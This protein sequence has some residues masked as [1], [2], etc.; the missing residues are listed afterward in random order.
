MQWLVHRRHS[1]NIFEQTTTNKSMDFGRTED[2]IAIEPEPVLHRL[3]FWEDTLGLL[4]SPEE[5]CL[6]SQPNENSPEKDLTGKA[7]SCNYFSS[8]LA[9]G[10]VSDSDTTVTNK[11]SRINPWL[12][13]FDHH[14]MGH[15]GSS[16]NRAHAHQCWLLATRGTGLAC[17]AWTLSTFSLSRGSFCWGLTTWTKS[18]YFGKKQKEE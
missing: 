6:L 2:P 7:A 3:W 4:N 15:S 18:G 13:P 17:W 14:P 10:P 9:P 12:S 11:P 8:Y 1:V 16:Q 5:G